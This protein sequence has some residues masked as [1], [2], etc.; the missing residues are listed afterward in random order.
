MEMEHHHSVRLA[1]YPCACHTVEIHLH[2]AENR[3]LLMYLQHYRDTS[4]YSPKNPKIHVR[5]LSRRLGALRATFLSL[6]RRSVVCMSRCSKY[7]IMRS[8]ID[9]G[10]LVINLLTSSLRKY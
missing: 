9:S 8:L 2:A 7:C 3:R 6:Q 4:P 1:D 10:S 5:Y